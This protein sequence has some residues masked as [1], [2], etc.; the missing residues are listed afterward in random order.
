MPQPGPA[1]TTSHLTTFLIV[2]I[3]V[4]ALFPSIFV[5]IFW[6]PYNS[7]AEYFVPTPQPRK[8][9]V[10]TSPNVCT[11]APVMSWTQKSLTLPSK[12]RGSYLIT[13][14]IVSQLPEIKSY[15]TGLLNLFIQHTSCALS[16]NENWDSDVRADMSTALDRIVPEDKKGEGLYRHDAEG[17]D[18]MPAHVKSALIGASVT[19]PITNGKLNTGTWQ[20][21]WYLEFRDVKHTRKVVA[22][23]QGEKM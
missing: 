16:L 18:D 3:F 22:T 21:I 19:V 4:I 2:S 13:D 17:S 15:K 11:S 14:H 10:C 6:A 5:G 9:V 20:G 1:N 23:I 7:I 12:S 8:S